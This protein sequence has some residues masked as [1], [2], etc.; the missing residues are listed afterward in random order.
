MIKIRLR[1]AVWQDCNDIFDWRNNEETR[2][3]S[4]NSKNIP[5]DVHNKWY[6]ESLTEINKCFYI[7][8]D[9]D[10]RKIGE[11]VQKG[12][13]NAAKRHSL[14]IAVSGIAPLGHFTFKYPQELVLKTLFTQIMLEHGFLATTAFY[15]SFAHKEQYLKQYLV[16][17]DLAFSL[18]S[19]AINEGTP[20]KYL[21][22]PVCHSGFKRLT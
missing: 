19:K 18:I 17:V 14:N 1:K 9:E 3:A 6:R 15:A 5:R 22:G 13:L 4:F 20:E 11:A 10:Q 2:K 21:Q 12:W 7:A 16:A 8:E